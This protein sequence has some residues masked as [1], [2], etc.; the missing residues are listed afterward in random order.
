MTAGTHVRP[1]RSHNVVAPGRKPD[2]STLSP[3]ATASSAGIPRAGC[4]RAG[5]PHA[6]PLAAVPV[7]SAGDG[8]GV[9]EFGRGRLSG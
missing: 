2:P 6:G 8:G 1:D 7:R 5:A 3:S 9:A 4:P